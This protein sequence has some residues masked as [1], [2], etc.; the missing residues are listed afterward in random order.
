M[1]LFI[2]FIFSQKLFAL[3]NTIKL[4]VYVMIISLFTSDI[5]ILPLFTLFLFFANILFIL[6]ILII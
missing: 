4:P 3:D 2:S 6:L 1:P 5:T